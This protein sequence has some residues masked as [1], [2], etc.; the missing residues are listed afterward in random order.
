MIQSRTNG[1]TTRFSIPSCPG[2]VREAVERSKD[3]FHLRG[4]ENHYKCTIVLREL[5]RN[6][7]AHGNRHDPSKRANVSIR[8]LGGTVFQIS[9][10]DEGMG[11]DP[12]TIDPFV[13]S[14]PGR[15]GRSFGYALIQSLARK[16]RFFG[17]GRIVSVVLSGRDEKGGAP[18]DASES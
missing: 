6:A 2:D 7:V 9:V 12:K 18:H 5:L 14:N 17:G 15:Q 4:L 16:I 11:F 13:S 3:F 1:E 8:D 10:A